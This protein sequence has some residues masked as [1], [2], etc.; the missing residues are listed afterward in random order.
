MSL[1]IYFGPKSFR[2]IIEIRTPAYFLGAPLLAL[3]KFIYY[4]LF[5]KRAGVF[6]RV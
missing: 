2:T 4:V 1:E 5:N 3:A 6:Y